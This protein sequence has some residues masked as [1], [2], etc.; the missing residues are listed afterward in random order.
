MPRQKKCRFEKK[1]RR[2]RTVLRYKEHEQKATIATIFKHTHKNFARANYTRPIEKRDSQRS[3]QPGG[4][5]QN[6]NTPRR[7]PRIHD[8]NYCDSH[9]QAKEG[10]QDKR[11][12][13]KKAL[14]H[15]TQARS[16]TARRR[17][18]CDCPCSECTKQ[19]SLLT[20]L[21]VLVIPLEQ[22]AEPQPENSLIGSRIPNSW[23]AIRNRS[24]AHRTGDLGP[25]PKNPD[26]YAIKSHSTSN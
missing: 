9:S 19:A 1:S 23:T 25:P 3:H 20:S 2:L 26:A 5:I 10:I 7:K 11:G 6:T 24:A 16:T 14:E 15:T 8:W 18:Y 17:S 12:K 22:P 21:L 4:E 13:Q